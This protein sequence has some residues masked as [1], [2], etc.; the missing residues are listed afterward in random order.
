[1]IYVFENK[2]LKRFYAERPVISGVSGNEITQSQCLL[3]RCYD[4]RFGR[5]TYLCSVEE[6][7]AIIR[8][9]T[10]YKVIYNPGLYSGVDKCLVTIVNKVPPGSYLFTDPAPGFKQSKKFDDAVMAADFQ[11]GDEVIKDSTFY[12]R[13][14]KRT[15]GVIEYKGERYSTKRIKFNDEVLDDGQQDN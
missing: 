10:E 8:G 3:V 5:Q 13:I 7:Q 2:G 15:E 4:K 14:G 11:A 12:A 6:Y 9:G 1:M